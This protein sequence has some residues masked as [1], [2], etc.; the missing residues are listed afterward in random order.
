MEPTPRYFRGSIQR[1]YSHQSTL[2]KPRYEY[3][4]VEL[5]FGAPGGLSGGPVTPEADDTKVMGLMTENFESTTY[6]STR[7]EVWE[8]ASDRKELVHST[9]NY[10]VAVRLDLWLE[11]L[12]LHVPYPHRR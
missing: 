5:S 10:G 7:T 3:D 4:A 11:W 1:L 2:G 8:G 12:N 9:I 6:L